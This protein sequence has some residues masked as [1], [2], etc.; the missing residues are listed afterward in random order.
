MNCHFERNKTR[1]TPEDLA[2]LGNLGIPEVLEVPEDLEDLGSLGLTEEARPRWRP[3][4]CLDGEQRGCAHGRQRQHL[5]TQGAS[6]KQDRRNR[7]L[8]HGALTRNQTG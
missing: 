7:G 1:L 6:R 3:C 2:N 8:D 5:S 4:A